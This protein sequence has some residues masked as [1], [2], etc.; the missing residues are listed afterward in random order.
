VVR[1]VVTSGSFDSNTAEV[2][3]LSPGRGKLA[4]KRTKLQLLRVTLT[5]T[6]A[7]GHKQPIH[8]WKTIKGR[9]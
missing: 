4:N 5:S 6:S 7:K 2:I 3:L 1:L 9:L 8:Y